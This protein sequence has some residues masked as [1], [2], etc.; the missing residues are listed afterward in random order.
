MLRQF[1]DENSYGYWTQR[2]GS[3][4]LYGNKPVNKL[5]VKINGFINFNYTIDELGRK[6]ELLLLLG[7]ETNRDR[8]FRGTRVH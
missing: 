6:L 1:I 5:H 7:N 2:C 4:Y 3:H 8:F